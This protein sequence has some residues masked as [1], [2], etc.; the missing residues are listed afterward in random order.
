[1]APRRVTRAAVRK[2]EGQPRRLMTQHV[3][4]A[5][6]FGAGLE[7][8]RCRGVPQLVDLEL[9]GDPIANLAGSSPAAT[10]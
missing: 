1:M 7:G 10:A 2:V 4:Q 6:D 8:E 3:P 9:V 5:L